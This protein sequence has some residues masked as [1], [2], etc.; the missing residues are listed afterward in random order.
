MHAAMRGQGI[1][2][3]TG[4]DASARAVEAGSRLVRVVSRSTQLW[5]LQGSASVPD[6]DSQFSAGKSVATHCGAACCICGHIIL[7]AADALLQPGSGGGC[8]AGNRA[9]QEKV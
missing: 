7:N 5:C 8:V 2:S 9:A 6:G 3:T 4:R 1:I